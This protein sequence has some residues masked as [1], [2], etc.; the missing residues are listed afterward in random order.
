[1]DIEIKLS[2]KIPES[3]LVVCN[4]VAV[5][6]NDIEVLQNKVE[7]GKDTP[8]DTCGKLLSCGLMQ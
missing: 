7:I 4:R 2:Y 5:K 1:M 8:I 6:T 3:L